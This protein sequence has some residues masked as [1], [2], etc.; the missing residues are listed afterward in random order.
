MLECRRPSTHPT[1]S[2]S[3]LVQGV[4]TAPSERELAVQ[5]MQEGA[6]NQ[7]FLTDTDGDDE[8]RLILCL[9][10]GLYRRKGH[11]G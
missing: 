1:R 4:Q 9:E 3:P 6:S 8:L 5:H 10:F 11:C 2:P 7:S